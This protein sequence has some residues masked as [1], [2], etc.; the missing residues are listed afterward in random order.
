MLQ[1]HLIEDRTEGIE[2]LAQEVLEINEIMTDMNFLVNEQGPIMDTLFDNVVS[3]N[4]S[5][6][7]GREETEKAA[8]RQKKV[9]SKLCVIMVGCIV[10][11]TII[12]IA[13][14]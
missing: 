9:N 4:T 7:K 6:N 2:R 1:S 8:K 10:G 12:C 14:T 11:I 3:T 13:L 5:I